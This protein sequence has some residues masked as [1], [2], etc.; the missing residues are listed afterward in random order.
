MVM[1]FRGSRMKL[2]VRDPGVCL[3]KL[4]IG[5]FDSGA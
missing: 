3:G 1:F 4:G 5:V 2:E